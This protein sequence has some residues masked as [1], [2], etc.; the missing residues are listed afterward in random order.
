MSYSLKRKQS[1]D[2]FSPPP[3]SKRFHYS[4]AM[5]SNQRFSP[6]VEPFVPAYT[7][8]DYMSGDMFTSQPPQDFSIT[9]PAATTLAMH[10]E[11][12]PAFDSSL[13]MDPVWNELN[14]PFAPALTPDRETNCSASSAS[15]ENVSA[16]LDDSVLRPQKFMH[17]DV[18]TS[19]AAPQ[20]MATY[21][22]K[23]QW[24]HVPSDSPLSVPSTYDEPLPQD[25]QMLSLDMTTSMYEPNMTPFGDYISPV[26]VAHA[27][28][29]GLMEQ[30]Y[31][32]SDAM[33]ALP[34]RPFDQT[35]R[36]LSNESSPREARHDPRYKQRPGADGLY[37]CPFPEC[38]H[39]PDKL[40]CNYE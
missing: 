16:W 29:S 23:P 13:V 37:H 4:S 6:T 34:S 38:D 17:Y 12:I 25:P 21:P 30:S 1:S 33:T 14:E 8:E 7:Q 3:E 10:L 40:K 11:N 26:S 32:P 39:E 19:M 22:M 35:T 9:M 28:P 15:S 20:V 36:R 2:L 24:I 31:S 27:L 18:Q 5:A